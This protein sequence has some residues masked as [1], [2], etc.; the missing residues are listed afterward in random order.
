[1]DTLY[2]N[3]QLDERE[4]IDREIRGGMT[5][6][7][8]RKHHPRPSEITFDEF[9]EHVQQILRSNSK[10]PVTVEQE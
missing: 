10:T 1:M 7:V 3:D 6:T 8:V 4:H 9:F 5:M 2:L